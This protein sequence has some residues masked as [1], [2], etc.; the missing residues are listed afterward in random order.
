MISKLGKASLRLFLR[1]F[2]DDRLAALLAHA[3]SG[4]LVFTSCCCFIGSLTADHALCGAT[5]LRV[6]A[7]SDHYLAAKAAPFASEAESVYLNFSPPCMLVPGEIADAER[8]RRVIPFIRAEI[9]RRDKRRA[10]MAAEAEFEEL[11][12]AVSG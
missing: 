7:N 12:A 11:V 4:K 10:K 8:R 6:I 5:S 3:Q 1:N 9:W 2:P